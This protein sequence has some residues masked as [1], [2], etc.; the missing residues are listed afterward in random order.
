MP[1]SE[2]QIAVITPS[3]EEQL[4]QLR[5]YL[6]TSEPFRHCRGKVGS[7][8]GL[9]MFDEKELK[10][11]TPTALLKELD[12]RSGQTRILM[13]HLAKLRRDG[14]TVAFEELRYALANADFV[15]TGEEL[16]LDKRIS[17]VLLM[18]EPKRMLEFIKW[19]KLVCP[20]VVDWQLGHPTSFGKTMIAQ[21]KIK[22]RPGYVPWTERVLTEN[23]E[24]KQGLERFYASSEHRSVIN[25]ANFLPDTILREAYRRFAKDDDARYMLQRG[26][27]WLRPD[28]DSPYNTDVIGNWGVASFLP[29]MTQSE[30]L[31]LIKR[32]HQHEVAT[33]QFSYPSHMRDIS[34]YSASI[35][36]FPEKELSR[37]R[38]R[39]P[40]Y[41]SGSLSQGMGAVLLEN[42]HRLEME[43]SLFDMRHWRDQESEPNK[44]EVGLKL[45]FSKR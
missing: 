36:L 29:E 8:T 22:D 37:F 17:G 5:T 2:P 1:E 16:P 45:H 34:G 28:E 21:G 14:H 35:G 3:P 24:V 33:W 38:K 11:A 6:A 18:Y 7:W 12:W 23:P 32:E 9:G 44:D 10:E 40:S 31:S 27:K 42:R 41:V 43:D 26:V 30:V 4:Q 25:R 20:E 19:V 15:I 39:W 13:N